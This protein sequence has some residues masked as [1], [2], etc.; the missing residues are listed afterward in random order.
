MLKTCYLLAELNLAFGKPA[1]QNSVSHGG[2]A[3]RYIF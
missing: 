3:D 1:Y 2:D